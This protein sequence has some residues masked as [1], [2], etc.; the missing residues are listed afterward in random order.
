MKEF[1]TK[2]RSLL[3]ETEELL[4]NQI[5]LEGISSAYYLSM[6]SWA[7]IK[8][9]ENSATFLYDHADEERM[10][11]MKIFKYVNE[12]GGHALQPEIS[13]IQYEFDSLRSVFEMILDHEIKVT[14][15]INALVEHCFSNKDFASFNF[16]QWYVTEQ[17]EEETMARRILELFD[18][19][20]E[21]GIGLWTIDQEIG[22][23]GSQ[24]QASE[25]AA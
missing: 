20:G 4:N 5:K 6:A 21:E 15:S 22:K 3:E 9:Y 8:G 16:L 12:A 2:N 11:M 7:E 19:I 13:G 14:K 10:H 23:L 25:G 24:M 18:I 17:R 1:I